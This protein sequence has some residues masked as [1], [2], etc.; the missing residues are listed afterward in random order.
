MK[1]IF[2]TTRIVIRDTIYITNENGLIDVYH[3][4]MDN[5]AN[6]YNL[7]I[8]VFVSLIA[9]FAGATW[10]YNRKIV[11]TEISDEVNKVFQ[12]EKKKFLQGQKL[13]FK[14]ELHSQKAESAR[15]F[16][17]FNFSIIETTKTE[18]DKYFA[19]ANLVFWWHEV[20]IN[21][22]IAGNHIGSRLGID[23]LMI[24]LQRI[25]DEKIETKFFP[26]YQ[27]SYNYEFLYDYLKY[28]D[29]SLFVER[30]RIY[31]LLN[32]IASANKVDFKKLEIPEDEESF[33]SDIIDDENNKKD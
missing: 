15:L 8:T 24:T 29:D 5:Q 22:F 33:E 7:I 16:A 20:F 1:L 32:Q 3:K 30:R 10:L 25:V 9:I 17:L 13:E 2:D 21:H 6:T 23:Q 18:Q 14:N 12:N 31:N 27:S 28:I 19:F 26:V 4:M 11:R